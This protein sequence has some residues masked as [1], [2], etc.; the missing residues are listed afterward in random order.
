[1]K[2]YAPSYYRDFKCIADKCLHTCCV[3]WEIDVDPDSLARFSKYPDVMRHVEPGDPAQIRLLDGEKCPFLNENGLCDM[4][5]RYGE[6]MLCSICADHPRFKNFWSD[7]VEIGLGLVCEEA[8][9]LILSQKEPL[10]LVLLSDDGGNEEPSDAEKYLFGV[11]DELLKNVAEE[12]AFARL[13]EY[14][15]YRHLPDALYD[16]R[17]EKRIRF[18]DYAV[19]AVKNAFQKTDRSFDSLVESA[20]IFSYDVE[21]DEEKKEEILDSL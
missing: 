17:L 15:I 3:G 6:K 16:D 10:S 11:R 18:V 14:F 2:I 19:D 12:G 1:M 21:Y 9:R 13:R 7:R 4:I 20:R 8:G 5:I